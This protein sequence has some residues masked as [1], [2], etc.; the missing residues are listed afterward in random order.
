[1]TALVI[2][3]TVVVA[4]QL[5]LLVGLLRS[6]AEILKQLHAFG[7]GVD[8]AGSSGPVASPAGMPTPTPIATQLGPLAPAE[9]RRAVDITGTS[10]V[11]EVLGL[12]T[13]D[14]DHDTV[15]VFLSSTCAGCAPYWREL[16]TDLGVPDGTRVVV[17]TRE[18][19]DEDAAA[20]ADLAPAGLAVVMS[21]SAYADLEIP[22]SP[23][24]VHVEG[25]SGRVRGEGTAA[26]WPA[27]RNLLLRGSA[28]EGSTRAKAA[29]DTRRERDAD[30]HLLAA[31]ISPGDPSL[32]QRADG[33]TVPIDEAAS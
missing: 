14:V 26:S 1:M 4:A 17:V 25:R 24:V 16:E 9:G 31:G 7:A 32:Y 23:Y 28:S 18:E 30:R 20:I 12:R 27:V 11:G 33:T 8:P 3:L 5:L 10:P 19:P 22:G 2:V 6:H 15:L 29:A 21:S 13:V